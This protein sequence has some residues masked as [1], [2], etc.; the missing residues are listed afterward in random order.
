MIASTPL[1]GGFVGHIYKFFATG[2]YSGYLP[3]APGTWGTLV[4]AVIYWFLGNM[5]L[6]VYVVTTIAFTFLAVWTADHAAKIFCDED[7]SRVVIDEMAGFFIT[8]A[9]HR[10]TLIAIAAGFFIFRFFDIVKPPP[11]RW[12]ERRF[13]GGAGIV[14]DDVAAGIYSNATLFIVM[15]I[16]SRFGIRNS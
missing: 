15:A 3:A 1:K 2:F 10:P 13:S 11:L 7:P 6:H 14:L 8:M 12:I 16:L 5:P 9:F 4:A